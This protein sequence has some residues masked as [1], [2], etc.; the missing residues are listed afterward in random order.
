MFVEQNTDDA[1]A[2]DTGYWTTDHT[3][4]GFAREKLTEIE[5]AGR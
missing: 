4:T 1:N 3:W 2:T 5:T